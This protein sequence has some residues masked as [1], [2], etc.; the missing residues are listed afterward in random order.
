MRGVFMVRRLFVAAIALGPA[1]LLGS[2]GECERDQLCALR[3]T[4]PPTRRGDDPRRQRGSSPDGPGRAKGSASV[5]GWLVPAGPRPCVPGEVPHGLLAACGLAATDLPLCGGRTVDL[6]A[7]A[8][9]YRS[10]LRV[11]P[12]RVVPR[13]A[14]AAVVS[15]RLRVSEERAPEP[16]RSGTRGESLRT[17]ETS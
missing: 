5:C 6:H 2:S 13:D 8:T 4:W 3:R 12:G 1:V 16:G 9:A 10:G 15:H 7:E 14:R 11:L 17:N